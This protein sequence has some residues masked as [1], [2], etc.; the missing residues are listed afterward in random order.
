MI[1][2]QTV[3]LKVTHINID[4]KVTKLD[5]Q[6]NNYYFNLA[7]IVI[8]TKINYHFKTHLEKAIF[9]INSATIFII[10]AE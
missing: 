7:I 3:R 5:L 8:K 1:L 2:L 10:I 9:C 4:N 6:T